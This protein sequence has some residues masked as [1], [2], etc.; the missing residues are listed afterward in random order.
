MKKY[1]SDHEFVGYDSQSEEI[2]CIGMI[3]LANNFRR[4]VSGGSAGIFGIVGL[5]LPRNSKIRDPNVAL[6]IKNQILRFEI[7]VHDFVLVKIFE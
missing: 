2:Y 3:H 1:L 7:A 6:V 5:E 4:H